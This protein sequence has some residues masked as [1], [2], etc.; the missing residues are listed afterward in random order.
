MVRTNLENTFSEHRKR[1]GNHLELMTYEQKIV[2]RAA[3]SSFIALS[4]V[5]KPDADSIS[6]I[7]TCIEGAGADWNI[8]EEDLELI[9][10]IQFCSS[11]SQ[12][13]IEGL[14]LVLTQH[15]KSKNYL[16]RSI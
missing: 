7:D 2:V 13:Y 3:L 8:W 9:Q 1:W 11:L 5:W 4:P 6:C 14:I 12:E 16:S 10:Y 15:I